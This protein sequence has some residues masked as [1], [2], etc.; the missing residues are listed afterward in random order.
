MTPGIVL[1]IIATVIVPLVVISIILM[2]LTIN[3]IIFLMILIILTV[4]TTITYNGS[5]KDNKSVSLSKQIIPR[6]ELSMKLINVNIFLIQIM[7]MLIV[8]IIITLGKE[9]HVRH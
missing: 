5:N 9:N 6:A 7:T 1:I 3:Q 8:A 2:F 4:M